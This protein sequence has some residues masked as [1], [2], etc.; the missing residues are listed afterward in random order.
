V[1]FSK[2]GLFS[3]QDD[4]ETA[5]NTIVENRNILIFLSFSAKIEY[6]FEVSF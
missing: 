2:T 3:L 4:N 5:S 6:F 1:K